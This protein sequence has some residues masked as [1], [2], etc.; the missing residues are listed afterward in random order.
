[1]ENAAPEKVV[2]QADHGHVQEF[3]QEKGNFIN[4]VKDQIKAAFAD[5]PLD[6]G[7]NPEIKGRAAAAAENVEAID[8]FFRGKPG[9][10]RD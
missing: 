5:K 9:H 6:I 4:V 1:M 8:C 2:E 10:G 7:I 3:G